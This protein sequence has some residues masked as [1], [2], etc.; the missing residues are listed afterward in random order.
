MKYGE[1]LIT[2]RQAH[3]L[4]TY[5]IKVTIMYMSPQV[6][7]FLVSGGSRSITLEKS[8]QK[9]KGARKILEGQLS[10]TANI[11]AAAHALLQIQNE[12]DNYMAEHY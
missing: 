12:I 10:P 11:E 5:R 1:F 7:R 9:N 6:Q 4:T 8:L 2:I 3:T